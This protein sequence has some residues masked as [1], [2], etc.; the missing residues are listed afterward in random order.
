MNL[1]QL[2]AFVQ[3]AEDG[4]FSKAAKGLFLTQPTVSAHISALEKELNIRLFIRN[5]KEVALSDDGKELYKYARQ[6]VDI[7]KKIEARFG[8]QKGDD[9]H[10]ITIAASTIPAQ[11]L[12]PKVLLKFSERYPEE[13][14]K[15]METDS[16][17]VVTQV[18]DHMVDIGFTGT[19]LEK[20]HCKYI[21]FYKDELA[22]I[23]PNTEKYQKL[24]EQV[25]DISWMKE[26]HLI[27][28]EE[29]S[30]TRKE[31]E[32]QLK[33]AGIDI[34]Q[35]DIIASIENQETIKRSV[36]QGM[37]I[38]VLSRLAAKEEEESGLLLTFPI[39]KADQG[40]DINLVYNKNYQLTRSAERFVKIVRE[41]YDI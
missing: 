25:G 12:L 10:C 6:I 22:I 3:V 8:S 31:A 21:P 39:P 9:K 34:G 7:E 33:A 41:V 16:S 11:Y 19:V 32:K 26:E 38:T 13:Q 5:T 14:L 28:R 24:K 1:K 17:Q 23:T 37:G 18:V 2:E 27:L 4:S 15:L 35:L 40:R 36:R 30:G 29:G 20:K